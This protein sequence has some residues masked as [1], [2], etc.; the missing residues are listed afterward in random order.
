[1]LL[2]IIINLINFIIII[3]ITS[4][5]GPQH[6]CTPRSA[7]AVPRGVPHMHVYLCFGAVRVFSCSWGMRS[8]QNARVYLCFRA[9]RNF[10]IASVISCFWATGS[11]R[12]ARAC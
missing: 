12:G 5:W 9:I 11:F 6:A 10:H 3:V 4:N 8:F 1:M 7:E 2:L